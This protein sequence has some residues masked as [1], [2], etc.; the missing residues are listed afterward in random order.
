[1][2]ENK[3][4]KSVLIL[5]LVLVILV[6][7]GIC[8]TKICIKV[9]KTTYERTGTVLYNPFIGFAPNADY[10][11]AVGD[12]R[13][14]YVDVTWK[15]LE[16]EEGVFDFPSIYDD[17]NLDK[18]RSE[19]KNV[20]FRFVCDN[21][22]DEEHMDIPE[23]LYEK[24]QDGAFYDTDYGKGYSP[25]Y[26][27]DEFIEYH[28]KAIDALG[29]E[30]G[31]DSFFCYI[32]LG[33]VGH[34]GEWHVKY[35]DGIDRLPGW[36]ILSQYV[37]PYIEAFPKAKILMRRPFPAVS[38][39]GL[40]VYNDMTGEPDSTEEWLSWILNGGVYDEA[41]SEFE[42]PE[43]PN[44]W[45]N[46]P[47]GGEF[48]SSISMED[49]LV[50][51]SEQTIRLITDSHMSFIG[52]KSP[53]ACDE[54]LSYPDEVDRIRQSLGYC[55][56]VSES[57]ITYC[58][59]NGKL[60]IKLRLCNYGVAPM[61][62]DWPVCIYIL[63][64]SG[65]IAERHEVDTKLSQIGAGEDELIETELFINKDKYDD[66]PQLVIGIEN[67]DTGKAEL[68]LDMDTEENEFMY[69]LNQ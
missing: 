69:M 19:G 40:G 4:E 68:G 14:V 6:I 49:L 9:Q 12:N 15:E 29:Q 23:W 54:E 30:F 59:L 25:N 67:P 56:G 34:W 64:D 63:D 18:W 62:F 20:V 44:V 39:S 48:T 51:N 1:M 42:L 2:A 46:A 8:V 10:I 31:K 22:S 53:I 37:E 50:S 28:K 35:G 24:T 61:Y 26:A 33:S 5:C 60:K 52:P 36:D 27:N 3:R 43:C 47:V 65:N 45:E 32:E 58:R 55:Y 16:P 21:P 13:L 17:N 41:Q 11:E 7:M 38:E 57:K 66:L